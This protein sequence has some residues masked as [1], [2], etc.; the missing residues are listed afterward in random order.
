[1]IHQIIHPRLHSLGRTKIDAI[2]LTHIFDLL[3]GARQADNARVE[4]GEVAL[5]HGRGVAG[6]IAGDED[7]EEW[8]FLGRG[9]V[10]IGEGEAGDGVGGLGGDK[11]EGLWLVG[12]EGLAVGWVGL[13]WFGSA[14]EEVGVGKLRRELAAGRRKGTETEQ[15]H[16]RHFIQLLRADIRTMREAEVNLCTHNSPH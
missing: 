3:P 16:P 7:G 13:G 10:G 1:M 2:R 5:Q 14:L 12:G 4:L 9:R 11:G 15:S 8:G 6:G